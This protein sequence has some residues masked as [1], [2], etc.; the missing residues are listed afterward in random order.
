[1]PGP[2]RTLL[3]FRDGL[4]E[5]IS[6][7]VLQELP[8]WENGEFFAVDSDR[9]RL[10]KRLRLYRERL[11]GLTMQAGGHGITIADDGHIP[12]NV[13]RSCATPLPVTAADFKAY[14]Q[15][16]LID[17]A[18]AARTM[19]CTRQNIQDLVRRGRMK[20]HGLHQ[21]KYTGPGQ[22]RKDEA[23]DGT[24]EQFPVSEE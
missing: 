18:E 11:T 3:F 7:T 19:G 4:V 10:E 24:Q 1:M 21:A 5:S 12:A 2:D 15:Q 13:L 20:D 22:T 6:D 23:C 14:L 9:G 8:L 17:T 16:E